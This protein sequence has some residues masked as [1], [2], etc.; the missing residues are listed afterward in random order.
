VLPVAVDATSDQG[1]RIVGS[2]VRRFSNY[3]LVS[4]AIVAAAGTFRAWLHVRSA[5]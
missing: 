4:V 2:V 5:S 3:A 1:D